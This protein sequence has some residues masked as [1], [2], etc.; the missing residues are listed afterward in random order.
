M[1]LSPSVA[2]TVYI[3]ISHLREEIATYCIAPG[4]L[5]LSVEDF[6]RIVGKA[7]D[8]EITKQIVPF[9]GELLRGLVERYEDRALIY[10]R[11]Q[12]SSDE[13]RFT[14]VKELCHI[15]IDEKEDWSNDGVAT[16]GGLMFE[17][18]IDNNEEANRMIQSE[19]WAEIAAIELM[20]PYDDRVNDHTRLDNGT[21][22]I[23]VIAGQHAIPASIVS[24]AQA[25]SFHKMTTQIWDMLE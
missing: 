1:L 20:Y 6:Q 7:Y 12:L 5:D 23:Q 4:R 10:I 21:T 17:Y 8:I 15:V 22:S 24:R 9:E 3:K 13:Q 2:K 16:I 19:I 14:A 18:S 11:R 25:E